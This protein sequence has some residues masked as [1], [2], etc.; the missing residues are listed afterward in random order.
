MSRE[1]NSLIVMPKHINVYNASTE[2]CDMLVGPCCCGAWHRIADWDGKLVN[3]RSFLPIVQPQ[4]AKEKMEKL[5]REVW[6]SKDF[7]EEHKAQRVAEI[8][9]YYANEVK[10]PTRIYKHKIIYED[11]IRKQQTPIKKQDYPMVKFK[12]WYCVIIGFATIID[13]LTM[14]L[15]FGWFTTNLALKYSLHAAKNNIYR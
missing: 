9:K 6:D 8:K 14:M 2:R 10:N 7:P 12:W 4:K 15:T 11:P 13:G 3:A 5:I 1:N